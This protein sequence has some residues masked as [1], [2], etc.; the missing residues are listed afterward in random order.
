MVET[1]L[2]ALRLKNFMGLKSFEL[3]TKDGNIT[4]FGDNA[5]GKST[6]E[7]AWNWLLFGK[8]SQNRTDFE[9]KTIDAKTGKVIHGLEH[10]VE[11]VL[12]V[13]GKELTLRKAYREK[14]TKKRGSAERTFSAH[15]TDYFIDKIPVKKN[16]YDA[17]VGSIAGSEDIFRLL[18]DPGYYNTKLHWQKRREVLLTVCGDV[19]D[20]DVI[21][22]NKDLAE[23]EEIISERSLTDH[24]K[25]LQ[26]RAKEINQELDKIPIRIDEV[27]Q[28]LPDI[29]KINT[30][31][32]TQKLKNFEK[33][34]QNKQEELLRL[35]SGGQIAQKT[36]DL[37]EKESELIEI[38][39]EH[40]EKNRGSK[41][42]LRDGLDEC[43]YRIQELK[44][45]EMG[46][47]AQIKENKRLIKDA[48]GQ[49][50]QLREEWHKVDAEKFEFEQNNTCPT[51]G[52]KLP[53]GKL[54][55][56]REKALADFNQDKAKKL[57]Q[58]TTVG[59]RNKEEI[60]KLTQRNTELE[61][62]Q[63]KIEKDRIA[64]EMEAEKIE[65][66]IRT[67]EEKAT[68]VFK[69]AEYVK[70][71]GEKKEIQN[72]IDVL[73]EGNEEVHLEITDAIEVLKA[74]I[75][76]LKNSL[77]KVEQCKKGQLRVGELKTQEK[78]FAKEYEKVEKELYLLD[79]FTRTKVK[80]LE[81][82][83]NS[84]FSMARFKLFDV[85]VN[86][87]I[88]ECCETTYLGVP[89]STLNNGARKNI[90]MD[91]INTLST[92]YGFIVPMWFD[93]R[94]AVTDLIKTKGQL[95]SLVVS[96]QDK[97]LRIEEQTEVKND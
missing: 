86:G 54:Q 47:E 29:S 57:E 34:K 60:E 95:I 78:E 18:T 19:S 22:S 59:K 61:Q 24:R 16:E 25:I 49:I 20:E 79:Q 97:T 7:T 40:T 87:G 73:K 1:R 6:L 84:K 91:I 90:G 31:E 21:K 81:E 56:A 53:E 9:L 28:G 92:F 27:V 72:K 83:I 94:E 65:K 69:N 46:K 15:T 3:R 4:I 45:K 2:R 75:D 13:E 51:C 42:E 96:K 17:K 55:E 43:K 38:K 89:Y 63:K 23:L 26:A 74:D 10:E 67:I 68:D 71:L 12:V 14:W 30:A 77:A 52:Q 93:N 76:S 35:E 64:L 62:A 85:L 8:D 80:L 5:T 50:K 66:E 48:K 36:R 44:S 37:R 39:N 70:R 11:G 82:K 33:E 88:E 58:I 41:D 32:T